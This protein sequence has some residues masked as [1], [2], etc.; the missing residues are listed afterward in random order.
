MSERESVTKTNLLSSF[1]NNELKEKSR[2][3][4]AYCLTDLKGFI[5]IRA[6]AIRGTKGLPASVKTVRNYWNN[7][8]RG[9]KR[10]HTAIPSDIIDSVTEVGMTLC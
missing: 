6:Y 8:T 4:S 2:R 3:P 1:S 7:F 10:K 5:R 9:W